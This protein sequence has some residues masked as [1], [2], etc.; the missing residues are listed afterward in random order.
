MNL[1]R[2]DSHFAGKNT[3]KLKKYAVQLC[4]ATVSRKKIRYWVASDLVLRVALRPRS[5]ESHATVSVSRLASRV[6]VRLGYMA[7]LCACE[8]TVDPHLEFE[9]YGGVTQ[10]L[11]YSTLIPG[12]CYT[13]RDLSLMEG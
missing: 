7:H 6:S 10:G 2:Y 4:S 3:E 9:P 1:K 5:F 11:V 13:S 8:L 12:Y